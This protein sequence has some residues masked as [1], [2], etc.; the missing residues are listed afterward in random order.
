MKTIPESIQGLIFDLDGT[1]FDSMG[2]WQQMIGQFLDERAIRLPDDFLPRVLGKSFSQVAEYTIERFGLPE[3]LAELLAEWN[4][5]AVQAYS[6]VAIKQHVIEYIRQVQSAG[7][8]LAVATS[9]A[10]ELYQPALAY[11]GLSDA[12]E[13]IVTTRQVGQGKDSP[14]IYRRAAEELNLAPQHC[15]VFEDLYQAVLS[16]KQAGLMVVGVRD[17]YSRKDWDKIK[18]TADGWIDDFSQAPEPAKLK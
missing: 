1:M 4:R 17:D 14:L 7:Y 11:H 15:L 3:S 5:R 18:Q 2:I 13:V 8:R 9:L 10:P 12:F 6:R 16:A